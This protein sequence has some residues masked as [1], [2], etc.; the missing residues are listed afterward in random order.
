MPR[1]LTNTHRS[2]SGGGGVIHAGVRTTSSYPAG[3][4]AARGITFPPA[5]TVRAAR[6][7][8]APA[9]LAVIHAGELAAAGEVLIELSDIEADWAA[10]GLTLETDVIVVETAGEVVAWAQVELQRAHA[11]VHPDHRSRG[12]GLALVEWTERWALDR[13]DASPGNDVVAV[14]QTLLRGQPGIDELFEGC[15]YSPT[16][17]SWVLRLPVGAEIDDPGPPPGVRIRPYEPGEEQA[18]YRVIEDAFNEWPGRHPRTFDEWRSGSLDHPDFRPELLFVA[19]RDEEVIGACVG[20]DYPSEGW[21]DQIAVRPTERGQ[22]LARAMLA[23]LFRTFRSRGQHRLGLNTDSR[24]G[25]LGLYLELGMEVEHTF[26]HWRRVLRATDE[27][28]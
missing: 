21:A 20:M 6:P 14:G 18:V 23:E 15:G 11:D 9:V 26:T 27:T 8:D 4:D 16:Y 7:G 19:A 3:V 17:D 13:A 22:G 2:G 24:T 5:Y 1:G 28:A 10:P 12:V 25:A